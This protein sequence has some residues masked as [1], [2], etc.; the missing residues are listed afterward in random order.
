M[1]YRR[2][3]GVESRDSARCCA[4]LFCAARRRAVIPVPARNYDPGP[5]RFRRVRG[6][7]LA[8]A[9]IPADQFC[10]ET[11]LDFLSSSLFLPSFSLSLYFFLCL[12][13]S[14]Y[15]S[16]S[17]SLFV[18]LSIYISPSMFHSLCFT[19]SISL[20]LF[21]SIFFLFSVCSYFPCSLVDMISL[22]K[23]KRER[24]PNSRE[25]RRPLILS[26]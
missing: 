15:V 24:D 19:L 6:L 10:S 26:S 25:W 11:A 3:S 2:Y 1:Y 21:L 13:L 14:L 22:R 4:M 18:S 16:F 23:R 12:S 7:Q 8:A 5:S 20:S 17:V 9:A